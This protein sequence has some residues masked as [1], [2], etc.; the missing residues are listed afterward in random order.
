MPVKGNISTYRQP[1]ETER[2]T[3][4]QLLYNRKNKYEK[5]RPEGRE[6][7]GVKR[8]SARVKEET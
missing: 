5:E 6:R 1:T 3:E 4:T 7:I 8:K 2:Q